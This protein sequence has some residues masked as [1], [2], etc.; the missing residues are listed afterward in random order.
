MVKLAVGNRVQG[1]S[2]G[3]LGK[4]G[5]VLSIDNSKRQPW[6]SV[7]W[8]DGSVQAVSARSIQLLQPLNS[9]SDAATRNQ[10]T[11]SL[12]AMTDL[13]LAGAGSGLGPGDWSSSESNSSSEE[14]DE[15][16]GVV[17]TSTMVSGI[18]N[19]GKVL[20]PYRICEFCSDLLVDPATLQR[21][22]KAFFVGH[23]R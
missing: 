3:T 20:A 12:E 10:P 18:S 13:L 1:K 16:D 21:K 22:R 7:H 5:V 8:G 6:Y 11:A 23:R 14:E 9:D 2:T 17:T 15:E 19:D 4:E